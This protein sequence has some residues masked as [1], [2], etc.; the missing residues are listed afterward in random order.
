M[1]YYIRSVQKNDL[2]AIITIEST[3]F[4]LKEAASKEQLQDVHIK[5]E[6]K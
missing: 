2:N 5:L 1:D 6:E 4:P 3:C